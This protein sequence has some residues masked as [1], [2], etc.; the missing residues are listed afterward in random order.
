[1]LLIP[2]ETGTNA[3]SCQS[4]ELEHPKESPWLLWSTPVI[5]LIPKDMQGRCRGQSNVTTGF[6][7]L[8]SSPCQDI[9]LWFLEKA[10]REQSLAVLEG[11]ARLSSQVPTLHP[12]CQ[13][14]VGSESGAAIV[15]G[16]TIR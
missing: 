16:E 13:L 1:M 12:Q 15:L 6:F 8:D 5:F 3:F 2:L 11:L 4:Q 10:E 9:L 14:R 7:L